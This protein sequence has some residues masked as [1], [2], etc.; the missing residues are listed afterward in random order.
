M[1]FGNESYTSPK[2]LGYLSAQ[3]ALAD[4]VYL[5]NDLQQ[6]YAKKSTIAK[7]LPVIA[8]G[9][10]YGG[11]LSAWLRIKYPYSVTG[12]IA[13]SAPVWQFQGITP[14]ETFNKIV[15]DVMKSLGSKK[16][17]ETISK[18]WHILR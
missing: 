1:P 10:S 17:V 15:T 5:I 8:F 16:C 12:A 4:Y 3:Q 14:C 9:G 13:S 2:Y 7:K 18:S 11:M 6:Q